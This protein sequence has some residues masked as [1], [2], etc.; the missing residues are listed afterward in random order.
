[1]NF[2][3]SSDLLTPYVASVKKSRKSEVIFF[4][5]MNHRGVV[6]ERGALVTDFNMGNKQHD[7]LAPMDIP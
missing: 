3:P 6:H 1:M 4:S 2:S 7:A 5:L